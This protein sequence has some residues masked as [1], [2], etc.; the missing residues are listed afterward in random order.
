MA[1]VAGGAPNSSI[2]VCNSTIFSRAVASASA[3]RSL[4]AVRRSTSLLA[5]PLGVC[6]VCVTAH[7]LLR[8]LRDY[9]FGG[10][11]AL[12]AESSYLTR[13]APPAPPESTRGLPHRRRPWRADAAVQRR[14]GRPPCAEFG[15][16]NP[17]DRS[18]DVL[19]VPPDRP[20][21]SRARATPKPSVLYNARPPVILPRSE[22]A[23]S[24]WRH[25]RLVRLR[26]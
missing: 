10:S 9:H 19:G 20:D 22:K 24:S 7:L 6:C 18:C 4:R 14:C 16:R 23:G 5:S 11:R 26:V 3:S 2:E 25:R 8:L 12:C 17:C 15:S 1:N 13:G 21:A